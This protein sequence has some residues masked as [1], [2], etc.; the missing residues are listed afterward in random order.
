MT[1]GAHWCGD[2]ETA[3]WWKF[4]SSH[5]SCHPKCK[6]AG[7]LDS[8]GVCLQDYFGTTVAALSGASPIHF[9]SLVHQRTRRHTCRHPAGPPILKSNYHHPAVNASATQLHSG[10]AARQRRTGTVAVAKPSRAAAGGISNASEVPRPPP[11]AG[12]LHQS[13]VTVGCARGHG[14]PIWLST[15]HCSPHISAREKSRNV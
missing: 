15:G 11:L 1:S 9:T 8:S 13:T 3:A 14:R 4:W 12:Q 5:C 7:T 6:T 2:P 10:K